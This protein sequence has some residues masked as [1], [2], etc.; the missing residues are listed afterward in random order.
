MESLFAVAPSLVS[1]GFT[2]CPAQSL[3]PVITLVKLAD[4]ELGVHRVT[5]NT[6][7]TLVV[8]PVPVPGG[9]AS[10]PA[11]EAL[12]PQG[13]INPGNK[14]APHGGFG[15]YVRGPAAF[16]QA[17]KQLGDEPGAPAE[18]VLNYDV[19]FEEGFE[20]VKGGKLPGICE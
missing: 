13:S 12:F 17:L 19:L 14:T 9:D 6:T 16:A 1:T 5:S 8:P 3:P 10:T 15:F 11:W 4:S 18:V 2:T 7:H 20:W